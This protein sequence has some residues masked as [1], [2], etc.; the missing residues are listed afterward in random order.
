MGAVRGASAGMTGERPQELSYFLVV[1]AVKVRGLPDTIADVPLVTELTVDNCSLLTEPLLPLSVEKEDAMHCERPSSADS[2]NFLSAGRTLGL[3]SLHIV[4]PID[5]DWRWGALREKAGGSSSLHGGEA[6]SMSRGG[7]HVLLRTA[8]EALPWGSA[9]CYYPGD[10]F[11]MT[12]C[13][14]E[15]QVGFEVYCQESGDVSGLLVPGQ[16][17]LNGQSE[18]AEPQSLRSAETLDVAF[19]PTDDGTIDCTHMSRVDSKPRQVRSACSSPKNRLACWKRRVQT[20]GQALGERSRAGELSLCTDPVHPNNSAYT[21]AEFLH[22]RRSYVFLVESAPGNQPDSAGSDNQNANG[23]RTR[24]C[25]PRSLVFSHIQVSGFQ[26]I[27]SHGSWTLEFSWPQHKV[28]PMKRIMWIPG[29]VDGNGT[30][31]IQETLSIDLPLFMRGEIQTY[32]HAVWSGSSNND[33]K[34]RLYVQV[35]FDP[36]VVV[37]G[38]QEMHWEGCRSHGPLL[39][40]GLPLTVADLSVRLMVKLEFYEPQRDGRNGRP[41]S[42]VPRHREKIAA[43][44]ADATDEREGNRNNGE[45]GRGAPKS[46]EKSATQHT[47][48]GRETPPCANNVHHA[49]TWTRGVHSLPRHGGSG[50]S[51]ETGAGTESLSPLHNQQQQQSQRRGR[52]APSSQRSKN[53]TQ[54]FPDVRGLVPCYSEQRRQEVFRAYDTKKCGHMSIEQMLHFCRAH[55]ALFDGEENDASILRGLRPYVASTAVRSHTETRSSSNSPPSSCRRSRSLS[56][57][58]RGSPRTTANGHE[59]SASHSLPM[60]SAPSEGASTVASLAPMGFAGCE[61]QGITYNVFEVIAL[62]LASM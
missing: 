41:T 29:N 23:F 36:I 6:A 19:V 35:E 32:M 43:A 18:L 7:V 5:G 2:A 15:V 22:P 50:V 49:E 46:V 17:V 16:M 9:S 27:T 58:R 52:G 13:G 21:D 3:D 59:L 54:M 14:G 51:H 28:S 8:D 12:P 57:E 37:V 38:D 56:L 53:A 4:I 34:T 10:W 60:N 39:T 24:A 31:E 40:N 26:P 61:S 62:R 55:V 45:L 30:A 44:A 42:A 33:P 47:A 1:T 25:Q 11:P 48:E 20:A